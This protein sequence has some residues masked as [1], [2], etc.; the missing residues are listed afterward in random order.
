[1]P[2][3]NDARFNSWHSVGPG[4]RSRCARAGRRARRRRA[5]PPQRAGG[6]Q[7]VAGL[8]PP[9]STA[10][11]SNRSGC[12]LDIPDGL[13][14]RTTASSADTPASFNAVRNTSGRRLERRMSSIVVWASTSS[15]APTTDG[16]VVLVLRRRGGHHHAQA[17]LV[18]TTQ[19]SLGAGKRQHLA[20]QCLILLVASRRDRLISPRPIS[21]GSS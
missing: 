20:D 14:P 16:R 13:S 21:R 7:L 8:A 4:H 17:Q 9:L 10:T 1:M 2:V 15:S 11:Q 19:Q 3:P 12:R 6:E 18:D 5:T